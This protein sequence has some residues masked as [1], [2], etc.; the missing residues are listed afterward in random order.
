VVPSC[1]HEWTGVPVPGTSAYA[2]NRMNPS[3]SRAP[4]KKRCGGVYDDP[5][6]P[7]GDFNRNLRSLDHDDW[8]NPISGPRIAVAQEELAPFSDGKSEHLWRQQ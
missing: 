1:G 6:E 7:S 8:Y 3:L 4:V 2:G 5:R